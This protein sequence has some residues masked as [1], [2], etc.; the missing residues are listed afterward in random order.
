MGFTLYRTVPYYMVLVPY[1]PGKQNSSRDVTHKK[2]AD[3]PKDR[4][5]EREIT[6]SRKRSIFLSLLYLNNKALE[7]RIVNG[8][9]FQ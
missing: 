9:A 5:K 3:A 2:G 6:V 1:R 8:L 7:E 4:L